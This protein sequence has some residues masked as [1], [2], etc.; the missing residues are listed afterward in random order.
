MNKVLQNLNT[1]TIKPLKPKR[2]GNE[3]TYNLFI[4]KLNHPEMLGSRLDCGACF[5]FYVNSDGN[6][7]V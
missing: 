4:T 1:P 3:Y 7:R 6:F 5:K 2:K